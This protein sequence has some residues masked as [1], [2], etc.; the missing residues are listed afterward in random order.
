MP[1][2]IAHQLGYAL[3]LVNATDQSTLMANGTTGTVLTEYEVV[4]ARQAVEQIG[5]HTTPTDVL[6]LANALLD[7][8]NT[9]LAAQLYK[10]LIA[11]PGRSHIKD[12]AAAKLQEI[13]DASN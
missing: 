11:V 9:D 12:T 6:L 2:V 13:E 5:W 8:G 1:R 10:T 7:E 3:A 4:T